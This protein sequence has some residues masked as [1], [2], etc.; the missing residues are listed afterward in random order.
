MAVRIWAGVLTFCLVR[1][2]PATSSRLA[3]G[4]RC[5]GR[6]KTPSQVSSIVNSVPGLQ[7]RET[8]IALG[9]MICPFV[10]SRVVSMSKTPVRLSHASR[11]GPADHLPGCRE[12]LAARAWATWRNGSLTPPAGRQLTESGQRLAVQRSKPLVFNTRA[13][14]WPTR[15]PDRA[16]NRL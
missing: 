5:A 13:G 14:R 2:Y 8:R 7:S 12:S 11:G 4:K 9:R 3:V 16:R 15:W 6:S 1:K 10:E